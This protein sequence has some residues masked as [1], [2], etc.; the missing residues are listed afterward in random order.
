MLGQIFNY[1][2]RFWRFMGFLGDLLLLDILMLL[3]A[4]PVVTAGVGICAAYYVCFKLIEHEN[5]GTLRG[6]FHSFRQN[7]RQGVCLTLI[8]LLVGIALSYDFQFAQQLLGRLSGMTAYLLAGLC[9]LIA[10]LYLMI[11]LYVF[12]LQAR[13][14]NPLTLTLRNAFLLAI[15]N[16]PRT[17]LMFLVNAALL[18][19]TGY[20]FLAVPQ[21]AIVPTMFAL[22]VGVYFNA[23]VLRG[24]LGLEP[25]KGDRPVSD[26]DASE[27]TA[28]TGAG[29]E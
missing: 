24:V 15:R 10:V 2:N 9:G 11:L 14:Y 8:L 20:C 29:T 4:L 16:L 25:G 17:A 3:C 18:C 6:F 26:E 21:A 27:E 1:E 22:P 19:G 12:P 28:R 23:W 13:F 7:L 5:T